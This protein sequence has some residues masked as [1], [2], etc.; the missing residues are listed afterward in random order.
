M[1]RRGGGRGGGV[2]NPPPPPLGGG[3]SQTPLPPLLSLSY[4]PAGGS[5]EASAS[6]V[7]RAPQ[8]RG[9]TRTGRGRSSAC[10]PTARSSPSAADS[11]PGAFPMAEGR[12]SFP[13]SGGGGE[14]LIPTPPLVWEQVNKWRDRRA[15]PELLNAR[16]KFQR[17]VR[18]MESFCA[19]KGEGQPAALFAVRLPL[20]IF[21]R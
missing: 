4:K 18:W 6:G 5:T 1:A 17:T 10:S 11:P 2:R 13:G 15:P 20:S 8:G 7:I 14:S 21:I 9:R 16:C 3:G 19:P 12:G